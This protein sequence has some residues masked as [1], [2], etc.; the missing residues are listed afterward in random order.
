MNNKTIADKPL[1]KKQAER[2]KAIDYLKGDYLKAGDTVY[3]SLLHVSKSG[4]SRLIDL[5]AVR[6][7]QPLC[8]TWNVAKA[9][10]AT[11]DR[12][13]NALRVSGAGTDAAF[14]TVYRLS[15]TLFGDGYALKQRWL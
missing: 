10:D 6:E 1:T 9:I 5:Y 7:N 14:A 15:H 4:M 8:I 12:R 2:I 13:G 3:T 11:Y